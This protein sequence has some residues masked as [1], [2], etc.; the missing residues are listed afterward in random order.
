MSYI[1]VPA[2][3]VIKCCENWIIYDDI[4][5]CQNAAIMMAKE[6]KKKRFIFWGSE[7]GYQKAWD[8]LMNPDEFGPSLRFASCFWD[9]KYNDIVNNLLT[10]AKHG[11][12]VMLTDKHAFILNF[13]DITFEKVI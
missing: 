10:L 6:S 9:T 2:E 1:T 11:D 5:N 13:E 4:R 12:P 7:I 3:K 8:N